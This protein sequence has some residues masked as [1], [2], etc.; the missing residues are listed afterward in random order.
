MSIHKEGTESFV[1]ICNICGRVAEISEDNLQFFHT[2]KRII[3]EKSV[4]SDCDLEKHKKG[5][6]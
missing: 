1:L 2:I 3:Q 6:E 4:C 5:G